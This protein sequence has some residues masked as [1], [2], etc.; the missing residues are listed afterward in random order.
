MKVRVVLVSLFTIRKY[1]CSTYVITKSRER[2]NHA[3]ASEFIRGT[4]T[5]MCRMRKVNDV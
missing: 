3:A 2:L 1:C 4:E 5:I